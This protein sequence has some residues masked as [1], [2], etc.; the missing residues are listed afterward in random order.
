MRL[1]G[2]GGYEVRIVL[3]DEQTNTPASRRADFRVE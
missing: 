1:L 3:R 2:W